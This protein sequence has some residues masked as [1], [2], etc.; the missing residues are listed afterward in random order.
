MAKLSARTQRLT[1]LH[2]SLADT[3]SLFLQDSADSNLPDLIAEL[4]EHA[5]ICNT[6]RALDKV[7][8]I[9][10]V[11]GNPQDFHKLLTTK[12]LPVI[13]QRLPRRDVTGGPANLLD[14][15]ELLNALA[16]WEA[17]SESGFEIQRFRQRLA[18]QLFT[19]MQQQTAAFIQRL[20]KA[21]Y[22]EMPQAGA[23]ILQLDATTWLLEGLGQGQKM[24]EL[25]AASARL[26]RSIVRSVSRTI[27]GFLSDS[28]MVRHFDVSAVLLYVEDLIVA[29]LRVQ[30]S[31]KEEKNKGAA[32]PFIL[33]LGEQ[34]A[35]A[36]LADLGALLSYYLRA[37]ERGIDTPKVSADTFRIFSTHAGMTLR[38]LRGLARQGGQA[39]ASGIYE[40]GMQRVYG[41][42]TKARSR[43]RDGAEPPVTEKLALLEAI[44]AD[45]EK[46]LVQII[47]S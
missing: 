32:H 37:L 47:P 18:D 14:L 6:I 34:I 16:T 15:V 45:F 40:Q 23:L 10:G 21:D 43:C 1:V 8:G 19:D 36:N 46:P 35:I 12:I 25:Q 11:D 26:A 13:E 42:Q 38:L 28:D 27:H 30:E 24:A 33:S 22:A 41:L 9:V 2:D 20:D 4:Q 44:T 7:S 39:K 29:M 3:L 31:T 17:R 5:H